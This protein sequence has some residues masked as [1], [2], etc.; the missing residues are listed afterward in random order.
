VPYSKAPLVGT[1]ALSMLKGLKRAISALL[2]AFTLY[3]LLGFLILPGIALRIANQQLAQYANAPASLQ[4][5]QLNPFSLELSAWGL[6]IGEPGEQQLGFQRLYANLQLDSLWKDA[7]HLSAIELDQPQSRLLFGKDGSFNLSQLFKLP[8]TEDADSETAPR[9][10]LPLRIERI[11]LRQ[12]NL[13]FADL[14]PSEPIEFL[15]DDLNIELFNLSTLP[16][17]NAELK[18]V[19]TGP[20]GARIDWSGTL[21]LVP[22]SSSGSLKVSDG[23]LKAIWPYVRDALPLTLQEGAFD[24]SSDYQLSL[25]EGTQVRLDNLQLQLAPFA[26][27]SSDGQ[28]GSAQATD[29]HR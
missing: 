24:F 23:R 4:R 16:E 21:S 18:L 29:H 6:A 5:L 27:S 12:G 17:D 10:P 26:I 13:H 25:S 2:I 14:R 20:T 1:D 19:A 11:E 7:L 28:P 3:S 15:Y 22:L 9:E 8:V